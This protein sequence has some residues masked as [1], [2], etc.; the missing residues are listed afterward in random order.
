M[1]L[2]WT[3]VASRVAWHGRFPVMV[4]T[5]RSAHDGREMEYTHLGMGHGAVVVLALDHLQQ[6]VCVRQYRHP[7]NE[8]T[9]E[10][11][12]GHVDPGEDPLD[13][14][15]RELE[16]ETGFKARRFEPLGVYTPVPSLSGFAMHMFFASDLSRGRQALDPNELLDV[17]HVPVGDLR[18]QILSGEHRAVSLTYTVLLA[19][20]NGRLPR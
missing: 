14:A 8:V 3:T 1:N 18:A 16:E 6:V 15:V 10:L 9:L 13:T 2:T 7:M 12:A 5:I 19:D 11:P 4:D 20:A 17:I